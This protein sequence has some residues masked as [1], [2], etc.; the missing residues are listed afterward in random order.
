MAFSTNLR[1]LRSVARAVLVSGAANTSAAY[2]NQITI[3]EKAGKSLLARL[4]NITGSKSGLNK[5][6]R[7]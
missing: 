1:G 6:N 5:F 3:P 4:K 2:A 7:N